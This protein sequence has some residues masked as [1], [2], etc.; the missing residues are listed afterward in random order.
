MHMSIEFQICSKV[1]SQL[2]V[3]PLP[4][5]F[6]GPNIIIEAF[7]RPVEEK[8]FKCILMGDWEDAGFLKERGVS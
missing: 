4:M 2:S 8:E 1:K 5:E 7:Q 6:L 3:I